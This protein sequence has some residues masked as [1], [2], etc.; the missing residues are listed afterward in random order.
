MRWVGSQGTWKIL[1]AGLGTLVLALVAGDGFSQGGKRSDAEVKISATST[2]L[3]STGKQT[4]I[5]NLDIN[6]GWHIYA[7]PVN[8]EDLVSAQ[9]TVTVRGKDQ[10]V[11]AKVKYPPGKLH[12]DKLIGNFMVYEDKITIEASVQRVA[13]D[14]SP[15]EVSIRFLA[16][17]DKGQC[18]LPAT[19]KISIK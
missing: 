19:I 1:A 10:T 17:H 9:T 8:N 16:C 2:K 13:G 18:L 7:N 4:I 15:L 14:T 5:L 6:K 12:Q 3:D 11:A